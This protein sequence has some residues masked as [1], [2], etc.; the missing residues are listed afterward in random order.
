VILALLIGLG[1]ALWQARKSAAAGAH[2]RSGSTHRAGGAELPRRIFRAS[3]GDQADPIKARQRS[4]KD[5]LDDGAARIDKALDQA[6]QAKLRVLMTL[7]TIYDDLGETE[8]M[9]DMLQKRVEVVERI[10]PARA[11]IVRWRTRNWRWRW[12]SSGATAKHNRTLPALKQ[13]CARSRMPMTTHIAQSKWPWRNFMR[14]EATRAASR[15]RAA[16]SLA[17]DPGHLRL[18]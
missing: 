11:P 3:G 17:C 1:V 13:R 18:K 15:L 10:T 7:A 2:R 5:L 16:L 6:P 12:R 8:R 4:A 14:R 9:A